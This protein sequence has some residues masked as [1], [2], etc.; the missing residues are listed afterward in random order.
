MTN[1]WAI[2][3]DRMALEFERD[4]NTL[5]LAFDALRAQLRAGNLED[6]ADSQALVCLDVLTDQFHALRLRAFPKCVVVS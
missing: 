4:Q 1:S 3:S 2:R 6:Q 5:V